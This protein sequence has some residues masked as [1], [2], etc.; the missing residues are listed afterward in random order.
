MNIWTKMMTALRGGVYEAG[1]AII[2]SQALRILDQEIRDADEELKNSRNSLASIMAHQKVAEEKIR[3]MEVSVAE[4]EGYA[5]KALEKND[6]KL[7]LE[8]AQKIA[9][10]GTQCDTEKTAAINYADSAKKLKMAIAQAERNIKRLKQQV[11]TVKANDSVQRAQ[12]AVAERHS[13]STSKMRTAIDSLER[14]KEKQ[15]L[16]D[17]QLHA[18]NELSQASTDESLHAKLESAGIVSGA[19]KA[20][21]VLAAL[22][23]KSVNNK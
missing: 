17:A 12:S 14:I 11:D 18:A 19:H 5:L 1:E 8:V 21:D 22:K 3:Q 9:D 10:L 15:A 16:K 7:A 13:G 23:A 4:Y 6:E 20:D 2:D